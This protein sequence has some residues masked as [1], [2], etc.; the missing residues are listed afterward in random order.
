MEEWISAGRVTVNGEKAGLGFR[1]GSGDAI[2]VDGRALRSGGAPRLPRVLLY[3]KPEGEIVSR[4]DPGGRPTVFERLPPLR[5]AKWLAV[6]RLD[7][8]TGG[9]LLLTTSG[10]LA[11]LM[12]HPRYE[13][14]REYAVRIRGRI[15]DEQMARLQ[16]GIRL[17][18]GVA[19]CDSVEPEGGEGANR[20]YRVVLHE[21]RNRVVR[22]LFAALGL[23]VSRLM[24]VRFGPVSLPPRLT[25]GH[26]VELPPHEVRRL[27]GAV[28]SP[29]TGLSVA[30]REARPARRAR[31]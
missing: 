20:W 16:A 14:P 6:G 31:R 28:G 3:H 8:N 4:D 27:L 18:D 1:V 15:S 2:S 21:G 19:R 9:L 12:M 29:Q 11:N 25:R 13:L 22:R 30:P 5:D 17:E 7:F 10:E 23:S 26:Y 24:R